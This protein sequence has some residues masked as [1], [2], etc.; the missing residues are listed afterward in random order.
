MVFS[1]KRKLGVLFVVVSMLTGPVLMAAEKWAFVDM[2][3]AMRT[4]EE[5]KKAFEELSSL[6]D[7]RE[8]ELK[9]EGES[10][11]NEV[12]GLKKQQTVL[13]QEA[14]QRKRQDL[15]QKQMT[16]KKKLEIYE[17]ELMQTQNSKAKDILDEMEKIIEGIAKE[18]G[19][20]I[21]YEK[22]GGALAYADAKRDITDRVIDS[23]NKK[24][25]EKKKK[26]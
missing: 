12:E 2:R 8:K 7:A 9:K 22:S 3:K 4:V 26:K 10:L 1:L 11:D 19:L 13:S 25:K 6:K 24:V 17:Q 21:I 23:Y 20:E 5:G 18:D 14:F 16:F 15:A